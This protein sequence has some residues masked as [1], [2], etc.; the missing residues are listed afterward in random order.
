MVPVL[1][2]LRC[3]LDKTRYISTELSENNGEAR[4][5]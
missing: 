1:K 4:A 3:L 2:A 5:T